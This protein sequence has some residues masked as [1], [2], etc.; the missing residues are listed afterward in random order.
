MISG[1]A[2]GSLL[3]G[4]MGSNGVFLLAGGIGFISAL[5]AMIAVP[6]IAED[7]TSSSSSA[8]ARDLVQSL[9]KAL[10]NL[11]FLNT[12][13]TIGIPAKAILTGVI[14]FAMPL[15]LAKSGY[16]QEDIGQII[17]V[18]AISVV[19]ASKFISIQ[20]DRQGDAFTVLFA[21]A[22]VSCIGLLMIRKSRLLIALPRL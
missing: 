18:Y 9:S 8:P 7:V 2:V 16:P 19:A 4:Y 6:A 21:G 5:Y 15:L 12:M 17:M 20:V 11:D 22:L 13:A 14:T 1:M 10:G 3:V